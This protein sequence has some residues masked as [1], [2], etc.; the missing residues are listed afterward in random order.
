MM[1]VSLC[2]GRYADFLILVD[3]PFKNV[4]VLCTLKTTY[5]GG[6]AYNLLQLIANAPQQETDGLALSLS[7]ASALS[8]L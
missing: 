6:I 1:P 8:G 2:G 5:R 7:T 3:D 4:E